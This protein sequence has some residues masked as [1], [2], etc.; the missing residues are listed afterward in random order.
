MLND[1]QIDLLESIGKAA[2]AG[3]WNRCGGMTAHYIAVH[4]P[5]GYIVFSMADPTVDKEQGQPIK[6]PLGE[7]N[8]NAFFIAQARNVWQELIDEN[9]RLRAEVDRLTPKPPFIKVLS[10]TPQPIRGS[11]YD[12]VS[13]SVS[14]GHLET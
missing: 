11:I 7:Q 2:T 4:S 1:A 5:S 10:D 12:R 8:A 9:R 3:P 6:A 14:D 13:Q